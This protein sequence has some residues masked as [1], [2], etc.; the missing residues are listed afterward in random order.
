MVQAI[1]VHRAG[2]PEVLTYES[3]SIG[4]PGAGEIK[5]RQ[6]AAGVNFLDIYFRTGMYLP[7]GGFPFVLGNEGAGEVIAVGEGVAGWAIGDRVAYVHGMGGYA[8]ERL[9]PAG[10]AVKVPASISFEQAAAMMLKGM[11]AQYLLRRTFRVKPEDVVLIHAAAGGVGAILCQ[12]AK[13]LG[14][15]VIGTVGSEAKMAVA[16]ANGVDF[17]INYRAESFVDRV[18]EVTQGRL[19]SV[20]YEGIGKATFPASLDCIRPLGMFVSYGAASGP[21]DAF[22][23]NLLQAKGSLFATRPSLNA[24]IASSAD[25]ATTAADLFDAVASGKVRIPINQRYA[26]KDAAKAHEQLEARNTTGSTIL[27][28]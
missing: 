15:T 20:V 6:H 5:I 3:I 27:L 14:A 11:T 1:R 7:P 17:A 10:R 4:P 25:L 23:I 26:L 12:W 28:I 21:V 2:G 13:A 22:D 18:K 24:Y 9:L 19:C 16:K 8:S